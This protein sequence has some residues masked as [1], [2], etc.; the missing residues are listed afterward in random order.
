MTDISPETS[1]PR[2]PGILTRR[3]LFFLVAMAL[4]EGARTLTMVQIPIYLRERGADITEIGLFFTVSMVFPLILRI[5]GGWLSDSV[6]RL[7]ALIYGSLFG[8]AAYLVYAFVPSWE[9][10]LS[11]PALIAVATSLV[12]PSYKAYIADQTP[13]AM[14]GRTF[15]ISEA[16]VTFSWVIGP[17]IGGWL[18]SAHGYRPLFLVAA[19]SFASAGVI[20]GVLHSRRQREQDSE[21][22][23]PSWEA[24]KRSMREMLGL[25]FSGGLVTWLLVTD[26]VRDITSKLSF[27]LMPVYLSDVA[28]ISKQGI[29]LLDGIFGIAIAGISIPAG[30]LVDRVSARLSVVLGLAVLILSRLI[31]GLTDSFAGFALSWALLGIGAGML[32]PAYSWLIARG[33]P[34]HLR[35]LT[36]GLMATSLSILSLPSP[37]IGG[38]LWM[39]ISPKAPFFST[40][41]LGILALVPAWKYL[42]VDRANKDSSQ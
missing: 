6:G 31:F 3:L 19:G 20:F 33:V 42:V 40:V 16:V 28:G 24:L 30:W 18:A 25:M 37:W 11:A 13:E 9:F 35:G 38:Q 39:R 17:P 29:G 7:R 23:N 36:F 10:A 12:F 14:R 8:A 34:R 32:D 4:V 1:K 22:E 27:D 15:G 5:I 41:I 26:A 2:P 21:I